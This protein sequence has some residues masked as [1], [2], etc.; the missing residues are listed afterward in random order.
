M[1]DCE[2]GLYYWKKLTPIHIIKCHN[3]S[4]T[5]TLNIVGTGNNYMNSSQNFNASKNR[6]YLV[7]VK[8]FIS[9][10]YL[11]MAFMYGHKSNI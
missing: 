3:Y 5:Y 7:K 8:V 9:Y 2:L 1:K 6:N 10:T 11:L 4:A